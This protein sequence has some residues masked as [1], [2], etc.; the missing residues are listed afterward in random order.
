MERS[1][2]D[3]LI[4]GTGIVVA[5]VLLAASASLLWAHNFIHTQ[6]HDQ[7]AAQKITFPTAG[8]T[9]LTSLPADD[10]AKVGQY[11]GQQL[12]T[13]AQAEVFADHYI[14]VHLHEIGG[15]QTYAQLSAQSL[16]QPTNQK[17]TAEV[18]TMFRGETL[19]GLL[20]NAY[21]FDTMAT[22]AEYA[23]IGALAGSVVLLVLAALGFRH[24]GA[25]K[26]Q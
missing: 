5:I 6:V 8:T 26:R 3:K 15:G 13:G 11:A 1:I 19:R 23:A 2:L 24:A 25:T 18:Q 17:L 7:L 20:L 16:A 4:S 10:Q 14:A 9:A 12:V 21:A 22:V